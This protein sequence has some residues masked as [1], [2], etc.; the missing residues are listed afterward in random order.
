M[1]ELSQQP[2]PEVPVTRRRGLGRSHVARKAR[3][4]W[5]NID[6]RCN[7]PK[8]RKYEYYGGRGIRNLIS[9][10]EIESLW[11]RDKASWMKRPSIDRINNDGHYTF[12]N[13][14]FIELSEN[15]S[16][17]TP[18]QA[19]SRCGKEERKLQRQRCEACRALCACGR[20]REGQKRYC[21]ECRTVVRPCAYCKAPVVRD[22]VLNNDSMRNQ[23]WFCSKREQGLWL[24]VQSPNFK[25]SVLR[26]AAAD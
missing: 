6:L 5:H 2:E 11:I 20:P 12:D 9:E 26:K 22:R 15:C 17:A 14:R 4:I 23:Q 25:K 3:Q 21:S 10:S 19:C 18:L 13:C 8:M 7:Y 16:K 24:T 1:S